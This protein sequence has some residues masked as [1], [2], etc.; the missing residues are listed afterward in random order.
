MTTP[1]VLQALR[2]R[3]DPPARVDL[4]VVVAR[5]G[6]A[7]NWVRKLP[8]GVRVTLYD[9]RGDLPASLFPW[10]RVCSL[11]NVGAE[12]HTYIRH[13]LDNWA[14]LARFTLFC[15]G[16]PFDHAWDLHAVTRAVASGTE[17]VESFRWLGHIVD[18]DDARGRRLFTKWSKNGNQRELAVDLFHDQ[19]FGTTCPELVHF[20]IGGQFI[21][22]SAALLARGREFWERALNL[23]TTFPDAAHCF[24]RLWD[25][26]C[27]VIA[28]DP[29]TL[30]PDGC[31]Y[32]KPIRPKT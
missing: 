1:T 2:R 17:Q 14:Q 16:H 21:A 8:G 31:R 28:V 32:L 11:P 19:L 18:T 25:R 13:I 22:S 10:A 24:E 26:V 30:G 5:Y 23:A 4:E 15:Q 12:A 9:K 20:H 29:L 27:G 3:R 7:V 6:E